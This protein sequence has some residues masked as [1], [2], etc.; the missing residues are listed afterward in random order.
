MASLELRPCFYHKTEHKGNLM[1]NQTA[2][3]VVVFDFE[4]TGLSPVQGDRAIEIGAVK[5]VDGEV[6]DS[7]SKLMNPGRRVSGF[8][9]QYTGISNEM[10]AT[11][12]SCADVM[13]QFAR[14]IEG[15]NLVA[16]N[17]SFDEKFLTAEFDRIGE[18]MDNLIGCS[19]L[20]S[21]RIFRHAPS[22]KL[23]ALIDYLAIDGDG[24]FHRALYDAQ[25]TG[26][27]WLKILATIENEYDVEKPKFAQM[28][29]MNKMV[30]S[31]VEKY[32]TDISMA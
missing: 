27:L 7:F 6:V 2:D 31:K 9:T 26:F 21:R 32:F 18:P 10:L 13:S 8:I 22:H 5:I 23:G 3:T 20:A 28:Q 25:M 29:K 4:T 1:K 30:K 11:A 19:L 14:F 17:A 16:H 15:F 12:P 24:E